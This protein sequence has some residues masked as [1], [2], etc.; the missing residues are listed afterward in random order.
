MWIAIKYLASN[1]FVFEEFTAIRAIRL[2][3]VIDKCWSRFMGENQ[4]FFG[5]DLRIL[6]IRCS[7]TAFQKIVNMLLKHPVR[8]CK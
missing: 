3:L 4:F 1:S 5:E 8:I 6:K 7:V 2:K